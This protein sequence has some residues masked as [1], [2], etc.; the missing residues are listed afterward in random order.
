MSHVL[1]ETKPISD[2]SKSFFSVT[3]LITVHLNMFVQIRSPL[4]RGSP[5]ESGTSRIPSVCMR[6]NESSHW[7]WKGLGSVAQVSKRCEN[8][9]YVLFN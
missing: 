8:I 7:T 5:L 9:S 3:V 6:R 1:G 4:A 2:V